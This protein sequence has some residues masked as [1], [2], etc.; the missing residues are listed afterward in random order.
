MQSKIKIGIGAVT[1]FVVLAVGGVAA[2]SMVNGGGPQPEDVLPGN[3]LAFTKL[4]LNPSAGQKLAVF[5]VARKFPT[6]KGRVGSE[7]TSIKES[8][9]GSI[10]TGKGTAGLGLD[11]KKDVEPWLGDRIGLGVFPD[12]DGDKVPEAGAAIAV[13]DEKAAK[14]A[15]DKIIAKITRSRKGQSNESRAP[16]SGSSTL[17]GNG[18]Y[19]FT[20]GYVVF[21]NTT[22]HAAAIVKAGKASSI[23]TKSLYAQD[24]KTLGGDQIGV[25]WMDLAAIYKA[26]PKDLLTKTKGPLSG[27]QAL[28]GFKEA[29]NP[30]KMSGRLIM[31]LHADSSFIEVTG[32]AIALKG[33][34]SS[35]KTPQSSPKVTTGLISTMPANAFGGVAVSGL[36]AAAGSM[37]TALTTSGDPMGIKS[38]L[39]PMGI[40]S[41]AQVETLLGTETGVVVAGTKDHPELMLRTN[42]NDVPTALAMARKVLDVNG[43][44][45]TGVSIRKLAEPDG[46]GVAFGGTMST[47]IASPSYAKLG[48]STL[49]RQ[50]VPDASKASLAEYLDLTRIVPLATGTNPADTAAWKPLQALG[51]TVID[52]AEPSVR[53]RL[54]VK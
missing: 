47:A 20:D 2:A 24:V 8:T 33:T 53:F 12:V 9:F 11:Y 6:I 45:S 5:Q 39:N 35:V 14:V 54:S 10:F 18:G 16:G 27:L 30:S 29:A 25:A 31:G 3:V 38:M 52:G 44:P 17:A 23:A 51:L 41:A 37:Y 1:A 22:A 4:D 46:I 19:A 48:D 13:T 36:G 49:F 40:T 43:G 50:V 26:I 34:G 42:S 7:D 21:S 15:L 28:P 32:R